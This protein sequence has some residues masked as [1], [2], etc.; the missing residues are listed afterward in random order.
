M[1]LNHNLPMSPTYLGELNKTKHIKNLTM[2]LAYCIKG[3]Y[4]S[5]FTHFHFA[6]KNN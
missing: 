4:F 5:V 6:D 1:K 2:P 3:V